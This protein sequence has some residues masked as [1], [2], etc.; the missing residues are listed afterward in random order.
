M[1]LFDLS[2]FNS[3]IHILA[4]CLWLGV[5]VIFSLFVVPVIRD[6]PE[7]RADEV[8]T[9]IGKRARIFVSILILVFI[10]TGLVNLYER[11]LLS[12]AE[13]WMT[14]YGL[15]AKVKISLAVILFVA[16]PVAMIWFKKLPDQSIDARVRRM[17]RLH[18]GITLVSVIIIGLGVALSP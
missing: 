16:F 10:G 13:L 11:G 12:S 8:L 15:M 18:W 6:M 1:A 4:A 5:T 17:D 14:T 3:L 2:D 9:W 7:E